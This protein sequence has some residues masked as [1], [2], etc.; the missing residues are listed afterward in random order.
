MARLDLPLDRHSHILTFSPNDDVH[1]VG[2]GHIVHEN[3]EDNDYLHDVDDGQLS[4]LKKVSQF[5]TI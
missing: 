4:F 1:D 2:Y 5:L 3:D